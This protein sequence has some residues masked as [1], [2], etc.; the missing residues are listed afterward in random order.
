MGRRARAEERFARVSQAARA[1]Y[2]DLLEQ[3]KAVQPR[4]AAGLSIA[5]SQTANVLALPEAE[6]QQ[7]LAYVENVWER[8][9]WLP[10]GAAPPG[11]VAELLAW[12]APLRA[13]GV[14]GC[15]A[16]ALPLR[17]EA[18]RGAVVW[19]EPQ[20]PEWRASPHRLFTAPWR[21]PPRGDAFD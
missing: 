10:A 5:P 21:S 20:P 14:P 2:G 8:V 19:E 1:V 11:D 9:L 7:R 18:A 4:I 15:D 13:A 17:T 6:A 16:S 12:L 3:L